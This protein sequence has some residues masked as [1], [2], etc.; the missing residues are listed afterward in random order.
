MMPS[1]WED[2]GTTEDDPC[3]AVGLPPGYES[4]VKHYRDRL[5]DECDF[6]GRAE[7][8]LAAA[9]RIT[10]TKQGENPQFDGEYWLASCGQAFQTRE[11]AVAHDSPG[12][13][14]RDPER[15]GPE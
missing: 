7:K 3:E 2:C 5:R 13:A 15:Q 11:Q 10:T 6:P 9:L 12:D 4:C 14:L 1:D 8:I